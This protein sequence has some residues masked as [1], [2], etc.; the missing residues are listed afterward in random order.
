MLSFLLAQPTGANVW[1][2]M[3]SS[4]MRQGSEERGLTIVSDSRLCKAAGHM[5][6]QFVYTYQLGAQ[7]ALHPCGR[8]RGR[9]LQRRV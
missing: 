9:A 5:P 7:G 8:G 4:D 6:F 3:V 2:D 1:F